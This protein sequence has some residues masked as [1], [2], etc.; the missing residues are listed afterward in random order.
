[1]VRSPPNFRMFESIR[2][3][4]EKQA[5]CTGVWPPRHLIS[6]EKKV[7]ASIS[8]LSVPRDPKGYLAFGLAPRCS[9]WVTMSDFDIQAATNSG[10]WPRELNESTGTPVQTSLQWHSDKII[11]NKRCYDIWRRTFV[12]N[13][14]SHLVL[15]WFPHGEVQP[16]AG[17]LPQTPRF[18]DLDGKIV[19]NLS[20]HLFEGNSFVVLHRADGDG[21]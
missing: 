21:S 15:L 14:I 4:P 10:V 19:K 3:D 1:M 5:A 18:P 2:R 16:V 13:Q 11:R 6:F 20:V 7:F 9:S 8:T 17:C 12:H